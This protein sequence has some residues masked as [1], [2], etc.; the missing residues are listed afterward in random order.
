MADT[1]LYGTVILQ[2]GEPS[3]HLRRS[4]GLEQQLRPARRGQAQHIPPLGVVARYFHF[5]ATQGDLVLYT[6][7]RLQHTKKNRLLDIKAL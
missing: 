2:S 6:Q 7:G 4:V 3:Q 1:Y 5:G